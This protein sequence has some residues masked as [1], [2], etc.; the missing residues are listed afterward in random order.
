M[1][2]MSFH[3]LLR[4]PVRIALPFALVTV[5][6]SSSN[7][8]SSKPSGPTITN[9]QVPPTFTVSGTQ[10]SVQGT[11]TYEDDS[12]AI[13]TLHEKIPM[14][15]LDSTDAA[16]LP[17]SGTAEIVLGFVSSA[18]PASG[19]QVQIDVSL[20]DANGNESNVETVT[21]GVP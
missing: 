16:S 6:C 12:A 5:A 10:Y 4:L 7:S 2:A 1:L 17:E 20:I 14:Y 3:S 13:T 8:S 21:V 11:L 19:T 18:A 9:I 15:N